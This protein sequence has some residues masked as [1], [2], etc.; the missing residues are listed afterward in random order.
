MC[1]F[2][3]LCREGSPACRCCQ[4]DSDL[5][6]FQTPLIINNNKILPALGKELPRIVNSNDRMWWWCFCFRCD[7]GLP[8]RTACDIREAAVPARAL[9]VHTQAHLRL[10]GCVF[11][12][13]AGRRP[14][15][16]QSCSLLTRYYFSFLTSLFERTS[17]F[18]FTL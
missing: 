8:E 6:I 1:G 4:L 11:T 14:G 15:N 9:P 3:C 10:C 17:I 7:S 18:W 12:T 13:T 5:K 2:W 16:R